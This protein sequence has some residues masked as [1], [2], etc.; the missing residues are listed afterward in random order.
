ML[1]SCAAAAARESG[2]VRVGERGKN[3]MSRVHVV[4]L[5]SFSIILDAEKFWV[6][7]GVE[8]K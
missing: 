5:S 2:I 1:E 3:E 7:F 4:S 6:A 8:C